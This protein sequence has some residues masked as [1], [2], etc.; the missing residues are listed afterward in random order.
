MSFV[1]MLRISHMKRVKRPC[2][3]VRL[4]RHGHKMHMIAQKAICPY[5]QRIFPA[6]NFQPFK[7]QL[8][9]GLF[10][11]HNLPVIASLRYVMRMSYA[12]A[13]ASLGIFTLFE[14][15]TASIYSSNNVYP[16]R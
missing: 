11:K 3:R 12:T 8:I 7:I 6:I 14:I 13:L 10:L 1:V 9:I 16:Y 15:E 5:R 4:P 2:H